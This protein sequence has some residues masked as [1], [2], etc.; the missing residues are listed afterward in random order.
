[1]REVMIADALT[2]GDTDKAAA[3]STENSAKLRKRW[4]RFQAARPSPREKP[5]APA[6]APPSRSGPSDE[7]RRKL[8]EKRKKKKKQN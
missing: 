2:R 1:M 4:E 8:R 3:I 6:P 7:V 5:E